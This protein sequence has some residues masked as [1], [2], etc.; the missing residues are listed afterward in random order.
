MDI[1]E[2]HRSMTAIIEAVRARVPCLRRTTCYVL[3]RDFLDRDKEGMRLEVEDDVDTMSVAKGLGQSDRIIE[4]E[5]TLSPQRVDIEDAVTAEAVPERVSGL[6]IDCAVPNGVDFVDRWLLA[7]QSAADRDVVRLKVDQSDLEF[8]ERIRS[9]RLLFAPLAVDG[10]ADDGAAD[11]IRG[12]GRR[13]TVLHRLVE[14]L[15]LSL[16]ENTLD[17]ME[18]TFRYRLYAVHCAFNFCAFRLTVDGHDGGADN[19]E[20][21]WLRYRVRVRRE[22]RGGAPLEFRLKFDDELVLRQNGIYRIAICSAVDDAQCFEVESL[23]CTALD[24]RFYGEL[25]SKFKAVHNETMLRLCG[26]RQIPEQHHAEI[27]SAKYLLRIGDGGG[28]ARSGSH[29]RFHFDSLQSMA[30]MLPFCRR[31]TECQLF[32]APSAGH[33]VDGDGVGDDDDHRHRRQFVFLR[34][35]VVRHS[36][37]AAARW[38]HLFCFLKWHRRAIQTAKRRERVLRRLRIELSEPMMDHLLRQRDLLFAMATTSTAAGTGHSV[39]HRLV[40]ELRWQRPSLRP[41]L[42]VFGRRPILQHIQSHDAFGYSSYKIG[43][44]DDAV[45][46]GSIYKVE[47]EDGSLR[48]H[49]FRAGH[50]VVLRQ[51]GGF[52]L[53]IRPSG[54]PKLEGHFVMISK[55]TVNV[56]RH[57]LFMDHVV[58]QNGAL[59]LRDIQSIPG[60]LR[61]DILAAKYSVDWDDDDGHRLDGD[62]DAVGRRRTVHSFCSLEEFKIPIPGRRRGGVSTF[63]LRVR[64]KGKSTEHR[65]AWTAIKTFDFGQC[66]LSQHS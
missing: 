12:D 63:T 33:E 66:A 41:M 1:V 56:D 5:K 53:W 35:F 37:S 22:C 24:H 32:V 7:V 13:R 39:L 43:E 21:E 59:R 16:L 61:H 3:I 60:R 58:P 52:T 26:W 49:R 51:N 65:F 25:A 44:S 62:G 45:I 23:R 55:F 34:K 54:V 19:V 14:E 2:R 31:T 9:H 17:F 46:A 64:P 42:C 15:G 27:L 10:D 57:A 36:E 38:N 4:E 48:N 8:M 28:G 6:Q 29:F 20:S 30:M 40:H 18:C 11:G 47:A 50:E